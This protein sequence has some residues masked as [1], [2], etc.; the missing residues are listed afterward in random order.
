MSDIDLISP[1]KLCP[2][3]ST[4][5]FSVCC[6]PIIENDDAKSAEALMRSRYTAFVIQDADYLIQTWHESTR[7]K[8]FQLGAS[9]W[10]GLRIVSATD[11]QVSFQAVFYTGSKGMILKESSRFRHEDEHWRYVDGDCSVQTIG[12]NDLCFCGSGRKFKQ[13]CKPT[14]GKKASMEQL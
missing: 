12:R 1:N 8:D 11:D 9:R 13:C 5:L 3:G 10:L 2:C 14:E 6:Q 4:L 7:P